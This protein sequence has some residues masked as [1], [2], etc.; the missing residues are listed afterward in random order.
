MKPSGILAMGALMTA[1]VACPKVELNKSHATEI[2]SF[3]SQA[4]VGTTTFLKGAPVGALDIGRRLEALALANP[5]TKAFL[6]QHAPR[7]TQWFSRVRLQ[8]YSGCS[9]PK[10][11]TDYK[12]VDNDGI[13]V[14]PDGSAF[15]YTFTGC[16]D[17]QDGNSGTLTG[18]VSLKDS[19]DNDPESGYTFG[20]NDFRFTYTGQTD[21]GKGGTITA[22]VVLALNGTDTVSAPGAAGGS[23]KDVQS[24][25][26][27][28]E[29]TVGKDF[30]RSSFSTDSSLTYSPDVA[31]TSGVDVFS[32]GYVNSNSKFSYSFAA[33]IGSQAVNS[34]GEFK[35]LLTNIF[36][37]RETCADDVTQSSAK[38]A[39]AVFSDDNN[40]VLKWD[41]AGC[42]SGS[43]DYNGA[44]L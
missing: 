2:Q 44:P 8:N 16:Q 26:F 23:Y 22:T 30:I 15:S 42:G 13:P 20:L 18:K 27:S 29:A 40:N 10:D 3:G 19:S 14:N 9:T 4:I 43:W 6:Q 7:M 28:L 37:D 5:K 11:G 33:A 38:D 35:L 31:A 17:A 21:D 36:I 39:A 12:D 41:V 32:R 24:S 25:K 34:S 1:L